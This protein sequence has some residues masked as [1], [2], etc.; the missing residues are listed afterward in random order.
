MLYLYLTVESISISD[1]VVHGEGSLF[2]D[3]VKV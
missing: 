3:S 2:R 1:I